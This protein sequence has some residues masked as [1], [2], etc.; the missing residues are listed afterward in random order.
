MLRR[1]PPIH[2]AENSV[3]KRATAKGVDWTVVLAAD[4]STPSSRMLISQLSDL[5]ASTGS[6]TASNLDH[7][8]RRPRGPP[9]SKDAGATITN[10]R[11]CTATTAHAEVH[12][13]GRGANHI[14]GSRLLRSMVKRAWI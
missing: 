7:R 10:A 5:A 3:A 12:P 2:P 4:L 8:V 1:R 9:R 13:S 14:R 11:R 6:A